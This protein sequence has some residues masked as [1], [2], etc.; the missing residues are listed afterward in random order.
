MRSIDSPRSRLASRAG[1]SVALVLIAVVALAAP[2]F[3]HASFPSASAFGFAPNPSGG[4]GAAGVAPP[5]VAGSTATIVA[6]VPYEQTLPFGG[7]DDTTVDVKVIVPAGWTNAACGEAKTQVNTPATSSTNQPG[8]VVAGWSCSAS[9]VAGHRVLHWSGPQV[10]APATSTSSAQF[11]TFTVTTPSPTAQ[12]TY[13]GTA[14]TEGFIIDQTYASGEVEHW[15]PNAAFPGTAPAGATTT[16][17]AGLVRTVAAAP[18]ASSSS[19]SSSTSSTSSTVVAS[20][21]SSSS[22]TSSSTTVAAAGASTTSTT[23][24]ALPRTGS[25]PRPTGLVGLALV[26]AGLVALGS[27]RR[28]RA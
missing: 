11:F 21:S 27:A 18:P 3:A 17:A 1:A 2:A 7:S 4:S 10:V 20:T 28:R 12:T 26:G 19:T 15:I 14:G 8:A 13:D 16:V 23:A 9:T 22:S 24:A 6:R 25:S 5:Y